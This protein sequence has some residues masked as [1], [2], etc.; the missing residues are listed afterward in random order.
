MNKS[1]AAAALLALMLAW[2]GNSAGAVGAAAWAASSE[3]GANPVQKPAPGKKGSGADVYTALQKGIA[4]EAKAACSRLPH[5]SRVAC[6][7]R[8]L[9]DT[10]PRQQRKAIRYPFTA[11]HA[12][13]WSYLPLEEAPRNGISLG[14]MSPASL[15]AFKALAAEALGPHGYHTMK[16]ILLADQAE[17][18]ASGNPKWDSRLYHVAFL[19]D[20]SESNPWMLQISG[21]HLAVNR[22]YHTR[23]Q[24]LTPMFVGIE[25]RI[26]AAG[27][28]TYG[29][30]EGRLQASYEL[31]RSLNPDQLAAAQLE[32]K[33][34]DVRLGPGRDARFPEHE[35]L[36]YSHL[37]DKQKRK[38]REAVTGWA[39]DAHPSDMPQLLA[40]YFAE[41]ALD[42]TYIGWSGSLDDKE[43]G[44]YLRIE[45]PRLWI[46]SVVKR[47]AAMPGRGHVH[48]VWRD[49]KA[50]YGGCFF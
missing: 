46:E 31:F 48:S 4:R 21:H 12:V 50:D 14:S 29:P 49:R 2:P 22:T 44:S 47:E 10:L 38:V 41:E 27:G 7:A 37:D 6:L 43:P 1:I 19:G 34:E 9:E 18:E 23:E 40:D 3:G 30:M 8:A 11:K 35:G 33:F 42:R 36:P 16:A 17:Q 20:P 25:P 39:I 32:E 24:G 13:N 45:G 5:D 28:R 26:S 15:E